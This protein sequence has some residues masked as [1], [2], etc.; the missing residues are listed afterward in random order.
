MS[1][2]G[3]QDSYKDDAFVTFHNFHTQQKNA[4]DSKSAA[5]NLNFAGATKQESVG[6]A[7]NQDEVVMAAEVP[8]KRKKKKKTQRDSQDDSLEKEMN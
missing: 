8:K 4:D 7:S 2:N 1:D 6:D 3:S 5:S